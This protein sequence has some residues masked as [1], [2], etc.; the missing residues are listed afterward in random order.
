[1]RTM[2]FAVGYMVLALRAL[3]AFRKS[4]IERALSSS[5]DPHSM[6]PIGLLQAVFTP[7]TIAP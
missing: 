2:Y 6:V 3:Q 7:A 4:L 5:L 1:M